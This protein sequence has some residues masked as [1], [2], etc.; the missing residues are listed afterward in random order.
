[1]ILNFK[2]MSIKFLLAFILFIIIHSDFSQQDTINGTYKMEF[3]DEY[4]KQNCIIKFKNNKYERSLAN[5]ATIR[6]TIDYQDLQVVLKDDKSVIEMH[7]FKKNINKEVISFKT[8]ETDK[9]DQDGDIVFYK[10]KLIKL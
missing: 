2:I 3:E 9:P 10:G 5:G 1:M 8:Y 4:V 6:G 7:F